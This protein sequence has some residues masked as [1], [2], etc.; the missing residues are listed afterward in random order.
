MS[1]PP[2]GGFLVF[3]WRLRLSAGRRVASEAA[4]SS[5]MRRTCGV[6]SVE[7]GISAA[8]SSHRSTCDSDETHREGVGVGGG[9][10][11]TKPK[12]EMVSWPPETFPQFA[13]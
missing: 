8:D 13:P 1:V 6:F 7:G 3:R 5:V 12:Q 11:E 2:L 4:R 9:G 10:E